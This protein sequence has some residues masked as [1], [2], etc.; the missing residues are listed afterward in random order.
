MVDTGACCSVITNK[1]R[2]YL[3]IPMKQHTTEQITMVG[4]ANGENQKVLGTVELDITLA[5]EPL[6]YE[7]IVLPH[8][9]QEIILGSN[10]FKDFAGAVDYASETV[11]FFNKGI[12]LNFVKD[13]DQGNATIMLLDSCTL[14]PRSETLTNV[15]C[16][17]P[18]TGTGLI[19][20]NSYSI[21][22]T[23]SVARSLVCPKNG[24]AVC[25]ILNPTNELITL[26]KDRI[27]A[28]IQQID[29]KDIQS[30][31]DSYHR[32]D[33]T[34][35]E[36]EELHTLSDLGIELENTNLT[37]TQKQQLVRLLVTNKDLFAKSLS[38]MPG[39]NL[40]YHKIDTGDAAPCRQRSYKHSPEAKKEIERQTQEMMD[41]GIIEPSHSCWS[42]P[43]LLVRKKT[44]EMRFC[45]D[46]RKLNSLTK[47]ISFPL[48]LLTDVF[49]AMSESTP[50]IFSLLDLKS[51]YWQIPMD[52]DSKQKTAFSTHQGSFQWNVL[53]FGL[54]NAPSS[55]QMLM[56]QVFQGMTFKHLIIYI[57]DLLVYSKSFAE[58]LEHLQAVF[59]RLRGAR[60]KL[61]PKKCNF[62]LTEVM[63]LGH[64]LTT[65]G[66]KVDEKKIE[67]IKNYPI[68]KSVKDVRSFLGYVGYYRKF[69][70]N[71]AAIA[72]PL[73]A[74]LKKENNFQW[75]K[76]CQ[77]AFEK[78]RTAMTT[79]PVL[80]YADMSKPFILTTDASTSAIGYVLSQIGEDGQEHPIA[81]NGRA[82]RTN[83]QQW[84]VSELEGLAL[85]EAVKEY[86]AFLSNNKFILY[87]DH[88]SLTWLQQIKAKN[89]RLL[90]WSLLLMGY[91]FEI[92]FK[93][94]KSNSNAD[95]LSRREYPEPPPEDPDDDVTNDDIYFSVI[96]EANKQQ[97]YTT[98]VEFEY[99][100]SFPDEE[101]TVSQPQKKQLTIIQKSVNSQQ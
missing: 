17:E 65:K 63:Y 10:F 69:V 27:L 38:D 49:D 4:M 33:V 91:N 74:L 99:E 5:N 46:Y 47:P 64:V 70:K 59:D 48:P 52:K 13:Q 35:E 72:S 55:F 77:D 78:L 96:N 3:D 18:F 95:A 80:M 81:C 7:F 90:R 89:G 37:E 12:V 93:S 6:P 41:S 30:Q 86:H 19:A 23:F 11:S 42:S 14:Q 67:V 97:L 76:E 24:R 53:P 61:H 50:A 101:N 16:K 66:V 39:T 34:E 15:Y 29:D 32:P 84:C 56:S 2:K 8:M 21:K 22:Q 31:E 1:F 25:R 40:H 73:H 98:E 26:N 87:T 71:F 83:E 28:T 75:T 54:M 58:H 20:P 62:A 85:V 60:L 36:I 45:V 44:G 94:G 68:P 79:T 57:D 43:V 92:R 82:L 51:G 100:I 9:N 88:V